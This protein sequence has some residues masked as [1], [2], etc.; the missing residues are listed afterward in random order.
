MRDKNAPPQLGGNPG[1]PPSA[2][3]DFLANST[4]AGTGDRSHSKCT[5]HRS[6]QK[7]KKG[8]GV[9]K[10]ALFC[11][12]VLYHVMPP[13]SGGQIAHPAACLTINACN[14]TCLQSMRYSSQNARSLSL[15]VSDVLDI[16]I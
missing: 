2:A 3:R 6:I 4:P 1:F 15:E 8:L 13:L 5:R 14:C 9:S 10:Q 16:S 11:G 7:V 12:H